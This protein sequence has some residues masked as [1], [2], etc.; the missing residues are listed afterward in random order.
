MPA[1]PSI[2]V[3]VGSTRYRLALLALDDDGNT[4]IQRTLFG[5]PS[6]VPERGTPDMDNFLPRRH[7]DQRP[8]LQ[9]SRRIFY[10]KR[11]VWDMY[12]VN[13]RWGQVTLGPLANAA[14]HASSPATFKVWPGAGFY[15]SS[16]LSKLCM[17]GSGGAADDEAIWLWDGTSAWTNATSNADFAADLRNFSGV[18]DLNDSG[19]NRMYAVLN[20]VTAIGGDNSLFLHT[21]DGTTWSR[22]AAGGNAENITA[23]TYS[24]DRIAFTIAPG[25]EGNACVSCLYSS[26]TNAVSY[27]LHGLTGTGALTLTS[28]LTTPILD[29]TAAPRGF[30]LFP[31]QDGAEQAFFSTNRGLFYADNAGA[32]AAKLVSYRKPSGSYTGRLAKS[33]RWLYFLDGDEVGRFRFTDSSG[34]YDV[35]YARVGA[36]FSSDAGKGDV[37]SEGVPLDAYGDFTALWADPD[38]AIINIAKGGLAASRNARIYQ[39]DES[40]EA[41][42]CDYRVGTAQRAILGGVTSTSDSTVRRHI[43]QESAAGGDQDPYYFDSPN[44]NPLID[45]SYLFSAS[46]VLEL[47]EFDAHAHTLQKAFL[48]TTVTSRSLTG[49]AATDERID[50]Q[51]SIDGA[52]Y[53]TAQTIG[54]SPVASVW[55]DG[56]N[57]AVGSDGVLMQT[58]LTLAR[59]NT[60]TSSPKALAICTEYQVAA[61]KGDNTAFRSFQFRVSLDDNDYGQSQ[62]TESAKDGRAILE[63]I[64]KNRPLV[65]LA[66]GEDAPVGSEVKVRL[67]PYE[68]RR[69]LGDTLNVSDVPRDGSGYVDLV[70]QEEV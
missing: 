41:W 36:P 18:V 63:T 10:D 14:T 34:A 40:T 42:T 70:F 30:V 59:G 26:T 22:R 60:T 45:T 12:N 48:K 3:T 28:S 31:A 43:A 15:Y 61:L 39:F 13:A 54:T 51:H 29:S 47:S 62:D 6:P 37:F 4:V 49:T 7:E 56:S 46:G 11:Y 25:P 55:T 67:Q 38:K 50:I 64:F 1:K 9:L 16:V 66:M 57:S 24:L 44:S 32:T 53:S 2:L 58:K 68:Q 33:L 5:F 52:S 21:T 65:K 20:Q 27:V 8:P 35:Q 23:G 19:T 69:Q 17:F